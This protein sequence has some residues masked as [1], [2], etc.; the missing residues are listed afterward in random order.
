MQTLGTGNQV[1]LPNAK[2]NT[3]RTIAEQT[4]QTIPNN[5]NL[6]TNENTRG[7]ATEIAE[8]NKE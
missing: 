3:P 2:D 1:V 8:F 6:T 7:D 4:L 5:L